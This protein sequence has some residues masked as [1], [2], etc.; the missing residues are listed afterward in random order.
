[1]S[2][3]PVGKT[4][5]LRHTD[6]EGHQHVMEHRVWDADLFVS[7][8]SDEARK[9]GGEAKIETITSEQYKEEK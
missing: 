8:R 3:K 1:M 7:T 2:A 9:A 5:Y 6:K 4:I